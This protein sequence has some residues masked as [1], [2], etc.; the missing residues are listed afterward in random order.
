[1]SSL[2]AISFTPGINHF[3]CTKRKWRAVPKRAPKNLPQ[4]GSGRAR[5][6]CGLG[7]GRSQSCCSA[8]NRRSWAR[9]RWSDSWPRPRQRFTISGTKPIR[10]SARNQ[11]V[12]FGKNIA[13]AGAALA[14]GGAMYESRRSIEIPTGGRGHQ[15]TRRRRRRKSRR[16]AGAFWPP[17]SGLSSCPRGCIECMWSP[18]RYSPLERD[19]PWKR[20]N[21]DD[22]EYFHKVVDCQWACPR[23]Y[24]CPL[25]TFD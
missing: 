6:R 15:V 25:S 3:F 21:V 17:E 22:P 13:L 23:P 7:G 9:P 10:I 16:R 19:N 1:M 2:V 18:R 8:C 5:Q 24:E 11:M 20:T 14:L 12:H 4:P